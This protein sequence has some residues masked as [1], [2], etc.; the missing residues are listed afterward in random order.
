MVSVIIPTLN[1]E[2]HLPVL[3]TELAAQKGVPL[4]VIVA[5]GGSRDSTAA[6]AQVYRA[7]FVSAERG[8][9]RQMNA[10]AKA[11]TG[12]YLLFLHADSRLDDEQLVENAVEA[13]AREIARGGG[14]EVAGHFP[15]LFVR[16]RGK[17]AR[18]YRYLE[19]KSALNRAGTTNGDQG[20]LLTRD[21]FFRLGGFDESLPF[22]ED[23]RLAERIRG[24]GRWITLPGRLS[25]S[26][27]RFETEGFHRRYTLMSM[28]MGL[29]AI[30][31][32]DFFVRAPGVYRLQ[33]QTGKLLLT[34]FFD[35]VRQMMRDWGPAGSVAVF[36]RLGRYIRQNSWQLFFLCDVWSRPLLGPGR[37]PF[38]A[39]HDRVV[40]PLTDFRPFDALTGVLCYLW[41]MGVLAPFYRLID[42]RDQTAFFFS[43]PRG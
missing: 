43:S 29:H 18:A 14:D 16:K 2:E 27:R 10:A 11:A 6:I 13:I 32:A 12:D 35:V 3:L 41:F 7:G 8:R 17:N 22:F 34:P 28:M 36:Y 40:A 4:E 1:E 15:L 39:V 9:G 21:F 31:A 23:Q 25:T 42:R 20:L 19:E 33:E 38:L 5:D 26:A 30:G 37:Y 24:R